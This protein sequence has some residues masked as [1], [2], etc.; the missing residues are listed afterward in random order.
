MA[1]DTL[2]K[3][4]KWLSANKLKLAEEKTECILLTKKKI[5]E[6]ISLQVGAAEIM[7]QR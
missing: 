7:I 5:Q 1:D 6:Q 2:R 3:A 4:A